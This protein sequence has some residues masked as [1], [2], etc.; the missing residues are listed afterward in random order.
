MRAGPATSRAEAWLRRGG[1]WLCR[2]GA[3]LGSLTRMPWVVLPVVFFLGRLAS[4][5]GLY[6]LPTPAGSRV[7]VA[8]GR[9]LWPAIPSELGLVLGITILQRSLVA[10]AR[11]RVRPVWERRAVL[12]G[13]LLFGL[14]ALASQT[15]AEIRR[16]MGQRMGLIFARRALSSLLEP[17]AVDYA[18][19]MMAKDPLGLSW[20]L[21]CVTLPLLVTGG[22]LLWVRPWSTPLL[23]PKPSWKGSGGLFVMAVALLVWSATFDGAVRKWRM[24]APVACVLAI[25]L[26][27]ELRAGRT[28]PDPEAFALLRQQVGLPPAPGEPYPL[29]RVPPP[30]P[31]APP[32]PRP[33]GPPARPD[34]FLLVVESLRGWNL[35]WQDPRL[36]QVAPN[37]VRLWQERGIAF[38]HAHSNGFPS[39]EGNMSVQLGLWS[40]PNRAIFNEFL[41]IH[42]LALP[43]ILGRHGY[44]RVWLT[45]SDPSIDNM[46]P[47]VQRWYD[48]WELL[49]QDDLALVRRLL[50]L[51]R[52]APPGQPRLM[53][54]YTVTMHPPYRVPA[55]WGPPLRDPDAAYQRALRFTDA[56]L[57]EL[58]DALRRT[59]RWN[60][61]FIA[62]VGDHGQPNRWQ[63]EHGADLGPIHAGHTWIGLLLAGP[64]LPAGTVQ[65]AT[66]SQVDLPP[67]LLARAGITAA[68]HFLGR[69]LLAPGGAGRPAISVLASGFAL[70]EGEVQ[71]VGDL[72]DEQEVHKRRYDVGL[73]VGVEEFR[74]GEELPV[75]VADR[76]RLRQ[77]A[78]LLR[79]Y[80][81]LLDEDRLMPPPAPPR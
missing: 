41:D 75:T 23:V 11:G 28:P 8:V 49:K 24:A 71:L 65:P 34:L 53:S 43:E 26:H 6:L 12:V 55:S 74:T 16:W 56:A 10:W 67:T 77:V 22:W 45:G 30:S 76:Q 81:S 51:Y 15:D 2:G 52:A 69:D 3:W 70:T 57:G 14:H 7:V 66:A 47:W 80:G 29:W 79:A 44:H 68:N 19:G 36:A 25:D 59:D 78:R 20:A 17:G 9:F 48:R 27:H 33:D 54:L 35:D 46:Q 58:F 4:I 31:Q 64:G 38:S 18:A 42:T 39:G 63:V 32:H 62:V 60:D 37:L 40:Y 1:A 13:W 50:E 73:P 5:L 21:L 72:W 61:T